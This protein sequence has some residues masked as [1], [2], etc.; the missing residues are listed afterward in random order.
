MTRYSLLVPS[1]S[2]VLNTALCQENV[3]RL[4]LGLVMARIMVLCR[5]HRRMG[6]APG[7]ATLI[8]ILVRAVCTL[9]DIE[10]ARQTTF[11]ELVMTF[12]KCL[13]DFSTWDGISVVTTM[14]IVGNRAEYPEGAQEVGTIW[15]QEV[16]TIWEAIVPR[17]KVPNPKPWPSSIWPLLRRY[18]CTQLTPGQF[19]N[20]RSTGY[21]ASTT[22]VH[23][24]S[25]GDIFGRTRTTNGYVLL[26]RRF[27]NR[28]D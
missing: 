15:E 13:V 21:R 8:Q 11:F 26:P 9:D 25:Q 5:Q 22:V 16:G 14:M 27:W 23:G 3:T 17:A 2:T 20:M 7:E 24:T 4:E 6:F 19:Q 12:W 28:Q 18:F 1:S 10:H